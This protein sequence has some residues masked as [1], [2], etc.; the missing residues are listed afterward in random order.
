MKKLPCENGEAV[1]VAAS[2]KPA[3]VEYKS[4]VAQRPLL[5]FRDEAGRV[6][7]EKIL[8]DTNGF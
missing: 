3:G 6:T 7:K 8:K 2:V 1:Y 5:L 4:C